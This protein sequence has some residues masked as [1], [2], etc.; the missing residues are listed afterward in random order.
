MEFPGFQFSRVVV[1]VTVT[2][3]GRRLIAATRLTL[4]RA[5]S[6]TISITLFLY[7]PSFDLTSRPV[8]QSLFLLFS[9]LSQVDTNE[10]HNG[11]KSSRRFRFLRR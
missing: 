1:T 5:N 3:C 7:S 10:I 4:T 6:L 9:L 2:C 11:A 8:L